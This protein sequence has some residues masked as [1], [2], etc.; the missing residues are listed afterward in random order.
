MKMVWGLGIVIF[1]AF[2]Q[3]IFAQDRARGQKLFDECRA[4]H[5]S[6]RGVHGIGPSLYGVFG[7]KAGAL[8]D[9]RYSPAM[10]RSGITW[11]PQTMDAFIA[12]PQK[13]VPGN[14]APFSG[15]P[16]ARDRADL[17]AYLRE[18]FK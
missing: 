12:D 5:A 15:I 3:G 2:P 16:D 18:A 1:I 11:T 4:C 17:I 9:F 13:A 14:R 10:R 7:R 8:E 6:E